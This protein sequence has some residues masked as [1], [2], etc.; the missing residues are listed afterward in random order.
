M[1]ESEKRTI[2]III[3]IALFIGAAVVFF[4]MT[5]PML[6]QVLA[7]NRELAQAKAEYQKQARAVQLA[8]TIV[9]QYK[10]LTDVNQMVSLTMPRTEELYNVLVQLNKISEDSGLI[11][12][13][14][15]LQKSSTG[16]THPTSSTQVLLK[17]PQQMSLTLSLNGTYEAF[18]TWLEAI[19]TNIRLMDVTNISLAGTSS[20]LTGR[21][22]NPTID[23]F[24][25]KVTINIYYQP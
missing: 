9:D 24:N 11:I 7:S 25:Y 17:T 6:N 12:Q 13:S 1:Q 23:F 22:T 3:I 14:I 10:N 18:K 4:T 16:T 15:S 21:E 8:K 2:S 20:L 19:E 5:W